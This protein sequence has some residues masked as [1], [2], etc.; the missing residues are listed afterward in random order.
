MGKKRRR[1]RNSEFEWIFINGKQ[2]KIRKELS[3]DGYTLE[4]F[5][6]ADPVLAHQEGMWHLLEMDEEEELEVPLSDPN[7][8][9]ECRR[10][11]FRQSNLSTRNKDRM[12]SL[13][14]WE[15]KGVSQLAGVMLK[16]AELHP[17]RDGRAEYLR[18]EYPELL[19]ELT[20]L[21]DLA[22]EELVGP[23][24]AWSAYPSASDPGW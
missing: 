17:K 11:L 13:A 14:L 3:V 6:R 9:K 8:V 5:C 21:A 2:K 1:A 22:G 23:E 18:A 19:K 15:D 12:R 20:R 24:P 7:F 10:L 4:D 16:I